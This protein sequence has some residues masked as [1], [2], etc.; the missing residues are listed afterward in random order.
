M[1]EEGAT[2]CESE[3]GGETVK[4]REEKH[5]GQDQ[6]QEAGAERG[7]EGGRE[8]VE[9]RKG[10]RERRWERRLGRY[11]RGVGHGAQDTAAVQ[12]KTA[13]QECVSSRM[14]PVAYTPKAPHAEQM[15]CYT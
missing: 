10:E 2:G 3:R 13:P 6:K 8:T 5:A 12:A 1:H 4:E 7:R 9:A 15:T 14:R 11:R